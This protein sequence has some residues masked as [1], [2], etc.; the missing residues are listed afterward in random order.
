MVK[1]LL[2]EGLR[3]VDDPAMLPV[4]EQFA[5]A[6][7]LGAAGLLV[8]SNKLLQQLVDDVELGPRAR[9]E[10]LINNFSLREDFLSSFVPLTDNGK[11][12]L[13]LLEQL[14]IAKTDETRFFGVDAL[15]WRKKGHKRTL[16]FFSGAAR[17]SLPLIAMLHKTF[18][19]LGCN[20]VYVR[21]HQK[22]W[23][24]AGLVGMP[25]VDPEGVAQELIRVH[26]AQGGTEIFT[27][28]F[29]IGGYAALRY[30]LLMQAEAALSFSGFTNILLNE[31]DMSLLASVKR[32]HD[33]NPELPADLRT[34]YGEAK[35]H[36]RLTLFYGDAH[37]RDSHHALRMASLSGTKLLP[38]RGLADHDTMKF[39]QSTGGM[40]TLM[41]DFLTSK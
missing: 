12:Q 27:V 30:G 16:F 40:P 32:L 17:R 23:H 6:T 22:L 35:H 13:M 19:E 14:G 7:S 3:R 4:A 33:H 31:L 10:L 18:K 2:L 28:G 11:Q 37:E 25:S 9:R 15:V 41:A 20:V 38:V 34:M 36:P 8:A 21:D 39:F 29:S 26:Q 24:L 1:K 5:L